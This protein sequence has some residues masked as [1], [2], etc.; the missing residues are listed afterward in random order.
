MPLRPNSSCIATAPAKGG[1]ISGMTP[2]VWMS[3]EPRK[4]EARREIG[5]RQ[6]ETPSPSTTDIA[7]T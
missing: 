3:T 5:Q 7:E 6:R 4:L 2:S 1:M